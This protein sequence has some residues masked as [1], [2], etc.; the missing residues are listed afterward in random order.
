MFYYVNDWNIT[1]TQSIIS[2]SYNCNAIYIDTIS[3]ISVRE[4]SL[5]RTPRL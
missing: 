4:N 3:A 5:Q 2:L 1:V